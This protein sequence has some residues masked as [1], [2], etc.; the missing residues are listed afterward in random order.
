[1]EFDNLQQLIAF[2]QDIVDAVAS[3]IMFKLTIAMCLHSRLNQ[4]SLMRLLDTKIVCFIAELA[5]P[6]L[7][8]DPFYR[9][10]QDIIYKYYSYGIFCDLMEC[11][12]SVRFLDEKLYFLSLTL[13][14]RIHHEVDEFAPTEA[15]VITLHMRHMSL[16]S[17]IQHPEEIIFSENRR[18]LVDLRLL[19]PRK[20]N[21]TFVDDIEFDVCSER[22]QDDFFKTRDYLFP[23]QEEAVRDLVDLVFEIVRPTEQRRILPSAHNGPCC[24]RC[25]APIGDGGAADAM[26]ITCERSSR[27]RQNHADNNEQ[28]A[29]GADGD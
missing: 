8:D 15:H 24:H 20:Q 28:G 7:S 3:R 14:E 29:G 27:F 9:L 10:C 4:N 23:A 22:V 18:A 16:H 13:D 12:F 25:G 6:P 1:M 2:E 26:C 5:V 19:D 11:C 17:F 21:E